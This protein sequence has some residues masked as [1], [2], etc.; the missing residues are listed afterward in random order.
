[1]TPNPIAAGI[2]GRPDPV[3]IDVSTSVTTAAMASGARDSGNPLPHKWLLDSSGN[4]TDN[5]AH[6]GKGTTILPIGGIDHGHKGYALSFLVEALSQGLSGFGRRD[7]TTQ[8]G[9]SVLVMVFAPAVFGSQDVFLDQVDFIA[10]ACRNA[11]PVPGGK[12]V[13][14]PGEAGLKRK[15]EALLHGLMVSSQISEDLD[16]LAR[17]L[18]LEVPAPMNVIHA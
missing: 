15:R 11:T 3:L 4:A 18:E 13:R 9:A 5:A 8:W 2:P 14:L 6:F 12:D 17:R 10:N 1:M 16:A 7:C